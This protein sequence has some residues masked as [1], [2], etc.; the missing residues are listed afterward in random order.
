MMFRKKVHG[1]QG[2]NIAERKDAHLH[3]PIAR[4][5]QSRRLARRS[6]KSLADLTLFRNIIRDYWEQP[7]GPFKCFRLRD[8]KWPQLR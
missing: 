5:N 7:L 3:L 1:A 4:G 2:D 8:D 6:V